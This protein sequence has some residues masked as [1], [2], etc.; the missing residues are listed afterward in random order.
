MTVIVSKH[1]SFA[2]RFKFHPICPDIL[3]ENEHM[4]IK[5]ALNSTVMLFCFVFF[6]IEQVGQAENKDMD[7]NTVLDHRYV[8]ESRSET[9]LETK[10][11]E[12]QN[13]HTFMSSCL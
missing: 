12:E 8:N 1:E 4:V 2:W 11:S 9:A 7:I 3:G 13:K 6:Y 5:A 10:S